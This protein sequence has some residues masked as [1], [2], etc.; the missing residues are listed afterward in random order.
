MT[1]SDSIKELATALCAFQAEVDTAKRKTVNVA[2]NRN[3]KPLKYADLEEVW[4]TIGEPLKNNGLAVIQSFEP[5]DT[6][7]V[8]IP[9][10]DKSG[11]VTYEE[12]NNL[13]VIIK[14]MLLHKSGEW[15]ESTGLR[16]P[17]TKNDPQQMGSA[18]TYGRRYDLTAFLGIY[19]EDDD[20]NSHNPDHTDKPPKA[21]TL[22]PARDKAYAELKKYNPTDQEVL[23][24][25]KATD[26]PSLDGIVL[27]AKARFE[28]NQKPET[29]EYVRECIIKN[30]DLL[31][32][33]FF[34]KGNSLKKN[35]DFDG[36]KE[37]KD[38]D[39]I[40]DIAL[41]KGYREHL[42]EAVL[43]KKKAGK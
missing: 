41:L 31:K 40:D 15:M 8:S 22:K 39:K 4:N 24:L 37:D 36:F 19:Q 30:W 42:R 20:G 14:T 33:N 11:N 16:L 1:K 2:Y 5:A 26:Q 6:A 28:R 35:I 32:Y 21:D 3:G 27:S 38:L 43:E 9:V 12:H 29:I 23:A 13:T 34:T 7:L 25:D 17:I 10:K 18:I